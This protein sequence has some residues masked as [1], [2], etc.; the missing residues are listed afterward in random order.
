MGELYFLIDVIKALFAAFII[1]LVFYEFFR[2]LFSL[3]YF[4]ITDKK[5][6]KWEK[7]YGGYKFL[8]FSNILL[9]KIISFNKKK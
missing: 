2:F 9:G 1:T 7:F 8:D 4:Y 6:K 5:G 3:L